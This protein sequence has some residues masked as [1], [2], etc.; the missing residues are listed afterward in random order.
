MPSLPRGFW[1]EMQ[2]SN[3]KCHDCG[4]TLEG[5]WFWN[6]NRRAKIRRLCEGCYNARRDTTMKF[7]EQFYGL[8]NHAAE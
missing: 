4:K 3:D 6:A 1:K 8:R 7:V 5:K 2:G